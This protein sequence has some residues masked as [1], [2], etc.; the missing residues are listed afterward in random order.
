MSMIAQAKEAYHKED[1]DTV[2]NIGRQSAEGEVQKFVAL[3]MEREGRLYDAMRK[4][5]S[6]SNEF[7]E[8]M[9]MAM[10]HVG[11]YHFVMHKYARAHTYFQAAKSSNYHNVGRIDGWLQR[12]NNKLGL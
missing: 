6:I 9:P 11:V 2:F 7:V 5:H 12:T 8:L 1:Y 3:S 4:W 10:F